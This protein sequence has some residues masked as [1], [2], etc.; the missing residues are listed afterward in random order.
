MVSSAGFARK[1]DDGNLFERIGVNREREREAFRISLAELFYTVEQHAD[2]VLRR[3]TEQVAKSDSHLI[4][5]IRAN[6]S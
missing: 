4:E 5:R 3:F 1:V 2:F 6:A